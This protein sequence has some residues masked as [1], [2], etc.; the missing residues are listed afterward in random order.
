MILN[1]CS[2][3]PEETLEQHFAALN[4][5]YVNG[6]GTLALIAGLREYPDDRVVYGF[7]QVDRLILLS[8]DDYTTPWWVVITSHGLKDFQIDCRV[9]EAQAPWRGARMIGKTKKVDRA[10]EMVVKSL[11]VSRG[12]NSELGN[13]PVGLDEILEESLGLFRF[14]DAERD[15]RALIGDWENK[16]R[17][18]PDGDE[19]VL[20]ILA[21]TGDD[22]LL[23]YRHDM[24]F[25]ER[26][27][28]ISAEGEELDE[29]QSWHFWLD[30]AFC[31]SQAWDGLPPPEV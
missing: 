4:R 27:G 16:S 8:Q 11:T 28:L 13:R 9:P 25:T 15:C 6:Q 5:K 17:V 3:Q 23:A 26:W 14:K 12:W 2:C 31:R 29:E 19:V 10:L 7:T 1:E 24:S 21:Q 18:Y 30:D 20:T 22:E